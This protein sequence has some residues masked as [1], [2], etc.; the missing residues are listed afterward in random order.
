MVSW[1]KERQRDED[2]YAYNLKLQRKKDADAYEA[3][4]ALEKELA[5]KRAVV[6]RTSR[7]G[8]QPWPQESRS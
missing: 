3:A 2:E 6:K 4:K 7:T 5:E 8:R 1:K